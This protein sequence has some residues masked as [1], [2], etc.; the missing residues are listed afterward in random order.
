M[1]IKEILEKHSPLKARI[2]LNL[3]HGTAF[4]C[5][6][7][8]HPLDRREAALMTAQ[9]WLG[10]PPLAV[11]DVCA[12]GSSLAPGERSF[13]AF[14]EVPAMTSV[15]PRGGYG[16]SLTVA[17]IANMTRSPLSKFLKRYGDEWEESERFPGEWAYVPK[18]V[19]DGA[20]IEA[21]CTPL[22]TPM[23]TDF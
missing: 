4:R 3:K 12:S 8:F 19:P 16:I 17:L 2:D 5:A 18:R 15:E 10:I 11:N 7:A 20:C 6:S 1:K 13:G 9:T 21:W 23:P 14:V 22:D